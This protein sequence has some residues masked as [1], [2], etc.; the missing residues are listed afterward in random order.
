MGGSP[1]PSRLVLP[2]GQSFSARRLSSCIVKASLTAAL[3]HGQQFLWQRLARAPWSD[4]RDSGET[5]SANKSCA[6]NFAGAPV[7]LAVICACRERECW[8]HHGTAKSVRKPCPRETTT[9]VLRCSASVPR[10]RN[11]MPRC[12][13]SEHRASSPYGR[14]GELGSSLG[15]PR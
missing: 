13:A 1:R 8:A 6:S 2:A 11:V 3:T 14:R 10:K 12:R 5:A 4:E 7:F 15:R 9:L